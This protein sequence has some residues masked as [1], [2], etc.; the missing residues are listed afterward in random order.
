MK[1]ANEEEESAE[2]ANDDEEE[3]E[4]GLM[5]STDGGLSWTAAG[6]DNIYNV[7]SDEEN[8]EEEVE[9]GKIFTKDD[10]VGLGSA[11][12]VLFVGPKQEGPY[13][14]PLVMKDYNFKNPEEGSKTILVR[15]TINILVGNICKFVADNIEHHQGF[16]QEENL[17]VTH[18]GEECHHSKLWDFREGSFFLLTK[19]PLPASLAGHKGYLWECEKCDRAVQQQESS[20]SR[21]SSA[22]MEASTSSCSKRTSAVWLTREG[23]NSQNHNIA[24]QVTLDTP[25]LTLHLLNLP[26]QHQ[27]QHLLKQQ[28]LQ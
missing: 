22:S 15:T 12:N 14:W 4:A 24:H 28:Q 5:G 8:E 6:E 7:E 11:A 27:Q 10:Y 13:H 18:K 26:W 16:G 25:T 20:K 21:G 19:G 1:K 23:Q 17:H 2:A 9:E 3:E